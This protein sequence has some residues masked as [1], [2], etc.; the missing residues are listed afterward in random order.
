MYGY[1][2]KTTFPNGK[3]YVGQSHKYNKFN[4]EYHGSGAIVV[5]YI[6]AHGTD[7]LI[8]E[9]LEWC[10][11]KDEL[12]KREIYWINELNSLL[13]NGYN[14]ST[15]GNGGDLGE[16]VNAKLS[17]LN[18]SNRM[19]GRTHS[20]ESKLKMSESAKLVDRSYLG[21]YMWITNGEVNKKILKTE[22]IPDSFKRGR[23]IKR[24]SIDKMICTRKSKTAKKRE[25]EE[26]GKYGKIGLSS[27]EKRSIS[28]TK[29]YES[30]SECDRKIKYGRPMSDEEK[31]KLSNRMK[32]NSYRKGKK[33]SD[34]TI[35]KLK[36]SKV[37]DG[38]RMKWWNNGRIETLSFTCPDGFVRGR[39]R[40]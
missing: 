32:G 35:I 1:I 5:K 25:Q 23:T 6:N 16:I 10:S 3:V 38:E 39:L 14:I 31:L 29:Y 26:I 37:R 24:E 28:S 4:P 22:P 21:D 11:S 27:N 8:T 9:L 12:N 33:F 36:N 2:Y 15:G 34:D 30:L 40:K 20:E 18:Q 13:P 7:G 19:H 17:E